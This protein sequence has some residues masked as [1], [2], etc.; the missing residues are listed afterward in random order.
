MSIILKLCDC[1]KSGS[2]SSS[3]FFSL[4]GQRIIW[5]SSPFE[6]S[7]LNT[8]KDHAETTS[9]TVALMFMSLAT[10]YTV[11][12]DSVEC[13]TKPLQSKHICS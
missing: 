1:A 9:Q 2:Y 13:T 12:T 4:E 10:S 11:E 7:P 5:C 3:F 6:E 8:L